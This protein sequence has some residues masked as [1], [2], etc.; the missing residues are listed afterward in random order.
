MKVVLATLQVKEAR[1]ENKKRK[2]LRGSRE[3]V[4]KKKN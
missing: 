2:H 1:K 3:I 4:K